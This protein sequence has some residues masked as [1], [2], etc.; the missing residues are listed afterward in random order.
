MRTVIPSGKPSSKQ[1]ADKVSPSFFFAQK[2]RKNR[3]TSVSGAIPSLFE[4]VRVLL[5]AIRCWFATD[6]IEEVKEDCSMNKVILSDSGNVTFYLGSPQELE[7][8]YGKTVG[9]DKVPR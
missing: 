9:A 5:E 6:W 8:F 2:G 4:C 1:A 3:G 7:N